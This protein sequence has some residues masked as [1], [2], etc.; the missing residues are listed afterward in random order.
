MEVGPFACDGPKRAIPMRATNQAL[1]LALFN[2]MRLH[3]ILVRV[4]FII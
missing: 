3:G 1:K 2:Q 4:V